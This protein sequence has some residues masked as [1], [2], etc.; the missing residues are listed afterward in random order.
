MI[1]LKKEMIFIVILIH[2]ISNDIINKSIFFIVIKI[3]DKSK[4][5]IK[6]AYYFQNNPSIFVIIGA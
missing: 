3:H 1:S 2:N 4:D 6:K 5:D